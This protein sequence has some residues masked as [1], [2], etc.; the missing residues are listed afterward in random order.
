MGFR[1]MTSEQEIRDRLRDE[2]VKFPPLSIKPIQIGGRDESGRQID[3]KIDVEWKGRRYRFIVECRR[4][5]T[6]KV[7]QEAIATAATVSRASDA[8]PMVLVPYLST[9]RL[10]A[11]EEREVSGIDLNGNGVVIVPGELLVFRGGERNKFP[12]SFP[13]KNPY[14]GDSSIV[15]RVFL[16]RPRYT[17]ITEI[18]S[19]IESRR[20]RVGLSTVSKVVKRLEDDLIVGRESGAIRALQPDKLL[21][22]LV[23]NYRPPK[24]MR[25]FTGKCSLDTDALMCIVQKAQNQPGMRAVLTGACSTSKYAVMARK[26]QWYFYCSRLSGLLEEMPLWFDEKSRFANVELIETIDE[27]VYFDSRNEAAYPWASPIQTYLELMSGDKRDRETA[28]QVKKRILNGI[29]D[30]AAATGE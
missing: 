22:Q 1:K 6:P 5:S 23:E 29:D 17:T 12:Q 14:R 4:T 26:D 8:Y 3:T 11:L 19:E 30:R 9:E 28:E 7:L 15:A 13:L 21:E 20:G 24:V 2:E 16:L 25:R 27:T 18:K 10:R